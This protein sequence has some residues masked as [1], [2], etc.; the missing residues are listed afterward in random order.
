MLKYK[1]VI[2]NL[3]FIFFQSF[4][5]H[6]N[7]IYEARGFQVLDSSDRG[8]TIQFQPKYWQQ[9]TVLIGQK[10]YIKLDFFHA[11]YDAAPDD[12]VIPFIPVTV[13]IPQAA[14]VRFS[15]L[16]SDYEEITGKLVPQ[17]K[18]VKKGNMYINQYG[19]ESELYKRDTLFPERIVEIGEPEYL[20]DQRVVRIILNPVQFNPVNGKIQMYQN[21]TFRIDY[22][23]AVQQT[24]A[25]SLAK[26][27]PSFVD[28][29]VINQKQ[30]LKWRQPRAAGLKKHHSIFDVSNSWYKI[31][32]KDEGIYKLSGSDLSNFDVDI[33]AID[34]ATL[35]IYNNGGEELPRSIYSSTRDTLIENA[36]IVNDG[37][38]GVFDVLDYIVFYGKAVNNWEYNQSSD[39]FQHY[40]NHYQ[41]HN[42]YW[43]TWGGEKPGKRIQE[44]HAA[45][46]Q[47]EEPAPYFVDHLYFEKEN[48]NFLNSGLHWFSRFFS[49]GDDYKFTVNLENALPDA[50]YF[51]FRFASGSG[52]AHLFAIGVNN[53]PLSNFSSYVSGSSFEHDATKSGIIEPGYNTVQLSYSSN[54]DDAQV[55]LD[56]FEVH[57]RRQ[58]AAVNDF[59]AFS[60]EPAAEQRTI[61]ITDFENEE[62]KVYDVSDFSNV[63]QL[64][65]TEISDK[66]VSFSYNSNDE[67]ATR[68]I[69]LSTTAYSIPEKIESASISDI[70][71]PANAADF[72]IITHDDFYDA[73][74]PLANYRETRDNLKTIVVKTSDIYNEFS[75]G[76]YDPTAIR[77]FLKYTYYNWNI[78]PSYVLLFGDGDYDYKNLESTSDNNWV[79]PYETT[80]LDENSNRASDD[81]FV[82][83]TPDDRPD[84]A[85]GRLPAR[86]SDEARIII[87]KIINYETSPI[88]N[89]DDFGI[90]DWR[91]IVTMVGDDELVDGG[92]G[93]ETIHTLDAEDIIE[94][95][96]PDKYNKEK[97]FLSEY[98]EVRNASFFS[99]LLKPTAAK[100]IMDRINKGTLIINYVGHG[101]PLTWSHEYVLYAPRDF[102]KIQNGSR[103]ALWVAATCDFG[104]FDDPSQQS[105]AE[106]L[107]VAEN[108]G[109]IGVLASTR[110]VYAHINAALNRAFYSRLTENGSLT[111][112]L[113]DALQLAK[114]DNGNSINDQKY[115]LLGD[116]TMRL[117]A[118]SYRAKITSISPDTIKA[119]SKISVTGY[120]EKN[121]Q[122]WNDFQGKMLIK[123]FDSK[124][125][126][127]YTTDVGSLMDYY[128]E[129]N[130]I[131]RGVNT[132]ENGRFEVSFIVPKDITY[133][134]DKG[135]INIYFTDN[136]IQGAGYQDSLLVGGTSQIY[137]NVGP[138]IKIGL[139][140]KEFFDGGY[141]DETPVLKID[142]SDSL[143]GINIT[144]DIGHS[145]YM[146]VD[147][148]TENK[149]IL[150]DLF[151][152]KEGSFTSGSIYYDFS[153]YQSSGEDDENIRHGLTEGMHRI[154]IKA[155]D[156]SNNSSIAFTD[157]NVVSSSSLALRNVLNFPN[158]FSSGTTFSFWANHDSEVN[159]KIYTVAG[160]LIHK[161]DNLFIRANELAQIEW[162]G[163]DRDGDELANGVYFYKVQAKANI[164]GKNQ[165]AD[166]IE[167]LIVMR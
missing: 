117:R 71:N 112:R 165:R 96:I 59:L 93:N 44:L 155:W 54:R 21:I 122:L 69:A 158:P 57:Y 118:P 164:N 23:G 138:E 29:L 39:R 38:D 115:V 45:P 72:I 18:V 113:G 2:L 35:K 137:D 52:G 51:K 46:A 12:P 6:G 150:T 132:V 120:I 67:T 62:I 125:Y 128:L 84:M 91:N 75:G 68:I 99:A 60:F 61:S 92:T 103:L 123:A 142:I 160:R 167:K 76:L 144:G 73:V 162:D 4:I 11:A 119:L 97:I 5:V 49:D 107:L 78:T 130:T 146:I 41:E 63:M 140:D 70:R 94:R 131:F 95:Y 43:L 82:R 34:P 58:F 17:P 116:P 83:V 101:N 40:I 31:Y 14:E 133:G 26:S 65:N 134:G 8:V 139:Q 104:R 152:Y 114:E 153:E 105:L 148:D 77:N 9:D 86:S 79:P 16:N 98:P 37:G 22:S 55:Y 141:A 110:L 156:N 13:G 32:I 129:G 135:R 111:N 56:W 109:A 87:D 50:A 166:V 30:A 136:E 127:R 64:S 106:D 66:G 27:K 145:I 157:L 33:K 161:F 47:S 28:K 10:K 20:R 3:V 80:E 108:K 85:I 19:D 159:I 74:M 89:T 24:S 90:D 15:I 100:D 1:F 163:R 151:Q 149:I 102:N 42:I 147:D 81:W 121:D 88:M 154:E 124:K 7:D 25:A 36:I 143:S 48:I 126:K 53:K